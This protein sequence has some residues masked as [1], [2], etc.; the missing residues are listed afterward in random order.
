MSGSRARGGRSSSGEREELLL[1]AR[2]AVADPIQPSTSVPARAPD[3]SSGSWR[4]A[5]EHASAAAST[6]TRPGGKP[7]GQPRW[8]TSTRS[9]T[10]SLSKESENPG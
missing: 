8:S 1:P 2:Q 9:A 3:D 7:Q 6:P 4:T 10:A 5:T